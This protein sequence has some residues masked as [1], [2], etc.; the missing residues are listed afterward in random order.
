VLTK[1]WGVRGI[2]NRETAAEDKVDRD[3]DLMCGIDYTLTTRSGVIAIS[4]RFSY[5]RRADRTEFRLYPGL[6]LNYRCNDTR[7]V[8]EYDRLLTAVEDPSRR[9]LCSNRYVTTCVDVEVGTGVKKVLWVVIV[10]TVHLVRCVKDRLDED[11]TRAWECRPPT[12]SGAQRVFISL[13]FLTLLTHGQQKQLNDDF[14]ELYLFDDDWTVFR[15]DRARHWT[16]AKGSWWSR[17]RWDLARQ[18]ELQFFQ[19]NTPQLLTKS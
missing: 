8:S 17:E 12:T 15:S 11:K 14:F 13:P 2:A 5:T 7:L 9:R 18:E 3:L 4:S 6:T 1:L 10:D 16:Y 19:Q